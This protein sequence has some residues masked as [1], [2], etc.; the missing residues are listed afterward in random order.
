MKLDSN[1]LQLILACTPKRA[2]AQAN[3]EIEKIVEENVKLVVVNDKENSTIL[4]QRGPKYCQRSFQSW[5]N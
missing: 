1:K 5:S 4:I 3:R 2:I